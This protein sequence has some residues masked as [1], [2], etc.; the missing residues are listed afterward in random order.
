MNN[1]TTNLKDISREEAYRGFVGPGGLHVA[2]A[3]A[4]LLD[5][6]PSDEVLDLGCGKGTSSIYIAKT[7]GCDVVAQ[8]LYFSARENNRRFRQAGLRKK[9]KAVQSNFHTMEFELN[10]FDKV[11]CL[12]AIDYFGTGD[13]AMRHLL[14]FVRLGG[15]V[16]ISSINFAREL[17]HRALPEHLNEVYFDD[18]SG[19]GLQAQHNLQW[20]VNHLERSGYQKVKYAEQLPRGYEFVLDYANGYILKGAVK[21][22][23]GEATMKF[24]EAIRADE[25][26][27]FG[28]F[29]VIA[30]KVNEVKMPFGK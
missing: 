2:E 18:G 8:D 28:M 29:I 17:D 1:S 7:Y 11:F 20:W 6:V 19:Y 24:I 25:G 12:N 13:Y 14:K 3:M 10:Q 22:K 27:N 9:I 26:K 15:L 5:L 16:G 4:K 21:F 30:K 23:R